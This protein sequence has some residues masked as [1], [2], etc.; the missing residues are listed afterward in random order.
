MACTPSLPALRGHIM[1][2]AHL[3]GAVSVLLQFVLMR[4]HFGITD[5]NQWM[6]LL[7]N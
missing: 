3:S 1:F 7:L 4:S 2:P 5:G 6:R